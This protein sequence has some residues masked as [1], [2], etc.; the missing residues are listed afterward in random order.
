MFDLGIHKGGT[1]TRYLQTGALLPVPV[2]VEGTTL[3]DFHA[4][5]DYI[6]THTYVW[7]SPISDHL[8]LQADKALVVE[9]SPLDPSHDASKALRC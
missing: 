1:F 7:V 5:R 8:V 6:F 3:H 4:C 9:R 2:L